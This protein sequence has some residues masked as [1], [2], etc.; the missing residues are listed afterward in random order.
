MNALIRPDAPSLDALRG[1]GPW[2][3][4]ATLRGGHPVDPAALRDTAY[5]GV[6]LGIPHWMESFAW[7][8]FMKTFRWDE[9]RGVLR[10]WNVRLRQTGLDGPVEPLLRPD[11]RPHTFGHYEVVAPRS[12]ADGPGLLIDYGRGGNPRW[13]PTGLLRDPLVALRPGDPSRLLGCTYVRL[14]LAVPTPSFFLHEMPRPLD[15]DASPP[16]T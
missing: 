12:P 6:S 15:H 8:T 16:R 1:M 9:D 10:G 7:T 14:G 5:R 2:A 4:A 3:L 13:D 11:G